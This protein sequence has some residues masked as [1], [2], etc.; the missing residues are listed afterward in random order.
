MKFRKLY[1]YA[2]T[3]LLFF[4]FVS[5][6]DQV[7]PDTITDN[8]KITDTTRYLSIPEKLGSVVYENV[9]PASKKNLILILD[10]HNNLSAQYNISHIL[11]YV[12][13]N[14]DIHSIYIEGAAG[15]LKTQDYFRTVSDKEITKC[16]SDVLL[17]KGLISGAEY[18]SLNFLNDTQILKGTEVLDDF[19]KNLS[20]FRKLKNNNSSDKIISI[21]NQF[22]KAIRKNH[23]SNFIT[24]DEAYIK[25][26]NNEKNSLEFIEILNEF[27]KSH[28]ELSTDDSSIINKLFFLYNTSPKINTILLKNLVTVK[29]QHEDIALEATKIQNSLIGFGTETRAIEKAYAI[30]KKYS[31]SIPEVVE[32]YVQTLTEVNN[33]PPQQIYQLVI[34]SYKELIREYGVAN[35]LLSARE[36]LIGLNKAI[37]MKLTP[38]EYK[39]FNLKNM[40]IAEN[41]SV[42]ISHVQNPRELVDI[43]NSPDS[44]SDILKIKND[45]CSFYSSVFKRNTSISNNIIDNLPENKTAVL[46]IGGFHKDICSDFSDNDISVSVIQPNI[47]TEVSLNRDVSYVEYLSGKLSSLEKILYYSWSTIPSPISSQALENY[48]TRKESIPT[49]VAR[50]IS[51]M[52]GAVLTIQ[53]EHDK[54]VSSYEIARKLE[55]IFS[56][57]QAVNNYMSDSYANLLGNEPFP[58]WPRFLRYHSIANK[59]GIFVTFKVGST[60]FGVQLLKEGAELNRHEAAAIKTLISGLQTNYPITYKG[61]H[62]SLSISYFNEY[63]KSDLLEDELVSDQALEEILDR[64]MYSQRKTLDY[65]VSREIASNLNNVPFPS[66]QKRHIKKF[67]LDYVNAQATLKQQVIETLNPTHDPDFDAG[68]DRFSEIIDQVE[69]QLKTK[70]NPKELTVQLPQDKRELI[71]KLV[72]QEELDKY[73]LNALTLSNQDNV[74]IYLPAEYFYKTKKR[75]LS[76]LKF[77]FKKYILR[78]SAPFPYRPSIFFQLLKHELDTYVYNMPNSMSALVESIMNSVSDKEIGKASDRILYDFSRRVKSA[79]ASG[80]FEN[81]HATHAYLNSFMENVHYSLRALRADKNLTN[82]QKVYAEKLVLDIAQKA[83]FQRVRLEFFITYFAGNMRDFK[84][85]KLLGKGNF[86]MAYLAE[87][88]DE[89]WVIKIPHSLDRTSIVISM[90]LNS[91]ERIS[92]LVSKLCFPFEKADKLNEIKKPGPIKLF[93]QMKLHQ[94]ER[95]LIN[96]AFLFREQRGTLWHV[97]RRKQ[98]TRDIVEVTDRLMNRNEAALWQ[99]VYGEN[100]QD[101]NFRQEENWF[102][103]VPYYPGKTLGSIN[104]DGMSEGERLDIVLGIIDELAHLG[105]RG[106]VHNDLHPANIYIL[107]ERNKNNGLKARILDYGLSMQPK[108]APSSY[109][110]VFF[111]VN[112]IYGSPEMNRFFDAYLGVKKT[113][114]E[115]AKTSISDLKPNF[116]ERLKSNLKTRSRYSLN[117]DLYYKLVDVILPDIEKRV[118]NG[119]FYSTHEIIQMI[120]TDLLQFLYSFINHQSDIYS[121]GVIMQ[122]DLL[123]GIKSEDLQVIIRKTLTSKR[124]ERYASLDNLRNDLLAY[125]AK[126]GVELAYESPQTVVETTSKF[127]YPRGSI[128]EKNKSVRK[129]LLDIGLLE[130]DI[131]TILQISISDLIAGR[132]GKLNY[133]LAPTTKNQIQS[134]VSSHLLEQFIESI[135]DEHDLNSLFFD[136]LFQEFQSVE[137]TEAIVSEMKYVLGRALDTTFTNT[138][139][140]NKRFIHELLTEF[141]ISKYLG[142][143]ISVLQ[144]GTFYNLD[145]HVKNILHTIKPGLFEQLYLESKHNPNT[146][147]FK[148]D[149]LMFIQEILSLSEKSG[150]KIQLESPAVETPTNNLARPI[151]LEINSENLLEHSL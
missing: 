117:L 100:Y 12:S 145:Q 113:L 68:I 13:E 129:K 132:L 95:F 138:P 78:S 89:Q 139:E 134:I 119:E 126:N 31:D 110:K 87:K 65:N 5:I 144:A 16:V 99:I 46:I 23:P 28:P 91:T 70:K 64:Q 103:A 98:S 118:Q 35:N 58:Q 3:I 57:S 71:I 38:R 137:A 88:N 146:D 77:L 125:A 7:N 121:L 20:E 66:S 2:T 50:Q 131:D 19:Y 26:V 22:N 109:K 82:Q 11:E 90:F 9:Q 4:L 54:E 76:E 86:G 73:N 128:S 116:L 30:L 1:K 8:S 127:L 136:S 105:R 123:K 6:Q 135:G 24:L 60:T 148:I 52:L 29:K 94:I 101:N 80:D 56:N 59:K 79:I 61:D 130:T 133:I 149:Q 151:D 115:L 43:F 111:E 150:F 143:R 48:F 93:I 34:E 10:A 39:Y 36:K 62:Y 17:N 47:D 124:D 21:I 122:R 32:K 42:L 41:C 15:K 33:L 96:T 97:G 72:P 45:V 44:F 112:T 120:D 106:V 142:N 25:F 14:T 69:R 40:D 84:I 18:F 104:T 140:S 53:N 49:V 37:S 92:R 85:K 63:K 114:D 108:F 81:L 83:Q 55:E 107:D 67:K 102:F 141:F 27:Q 75:F 147:E 74:E 51:L